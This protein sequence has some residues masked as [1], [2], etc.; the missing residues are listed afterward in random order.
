MISTVMVRSV[1]RPLYVGVESV[2]QRSACSACLSDALAGALSLDL[3]GRSR[4]QRTLLG[5][6]SLT[7]LPAR[8]RQ[9][10]PAWCSEPSFSADASLSQLFSCP[11][12][13]VVG[14]NLCYRHWCIQHVWRLPSLFSIAEGAHV[15]WGGVVRECLA[16]ARYH[17]LLPRAEPLARWS[18]HMLS[19][20]HGS[21]CHSASLALSTCF[22]RSLWP[23]ILRAGATWGALAA[24]WLVLG[25]LSHCFS[26][27]TLSA[28]HLPSR[29][30]GAGGEMVYGAGH[31]CL[32]GEAFLTRA[33]LV[34]GR[35]GLRSRG[36]RL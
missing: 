13:C 33:P 5:D 8:L 34:W 2:V 19:L 28:G 23:F 6:A 15:Q 24:G 3:P 22:Q 27:P 25:V 12:G 20:A 29:L 26:V 16:C 10:Q 30:H 17:A 21:T 31:P 7:S 14:H 11:P 36:S 4:E 1:T 9:E 35:P 32:L 18:R